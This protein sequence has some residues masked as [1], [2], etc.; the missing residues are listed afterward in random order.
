M[1]N[2][3]PVTNIN[4]MTSSSLAIDTNAEVYPGVKSSRLSPGN[5]SCNLCFREDELIGVQLN[6]RNL[7]EFERMVIASC[8]IKFNKNNI[9]ITSNYSIK[10]EK[11][12]RNEIKQG[13]FAGK[14][15]IF[16]DYCLH[17]DVDEPDTMPMQT[18]SKNFFDHGDAPR[19][20]LKEQLGEVL[21]SLVDKGLLEERFANSIEQFVEHAKKT[22]KKN[23][24]VIAAIKR[25]E[26][27]KLKE[28]LPIDQLNILEL[29]SLYAAIQKYRAVE[30]GV[31]LDSLVYGE[32]TSSIEQNEGNVPL[33]IDSQTAL[34]EEK[35]LDREPSIRQPVATENATSLARANSFST[36]QVYMAPI[37]LPALHQVISSSASANKTN[38]SIHASTS[39][40][41]DKQEL[42]EQNKRILERDMNKAWNETH[43][44]TELHSSKTEQML[45][46]ESQSESLHNTTQIKVNAP[47]P[48]SLGF[49]KERSQ[50][51]RN[52]SIDHDTILSEDKDFDKEDSMLSDLTLEAV[53]SLEESIQPSKF[54][55]DPMERIRNFG[56]FS[57]N[58]RELFAETPIQI[59]NQQGSVKLTLAKSTSP[60]TLS[61]YSKRPAI[62]QKAESKHSERI[63]PTRGIIKATF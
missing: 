39:S 36:A 57:E 7:P 29:D 41:K 38:F 10:Q 25:D 15:S 11:Q 52:N 6:Y 19:K 31:Y 56:I 58:G 30:C 32:M 12:E 33:Q 4:I 45:T 50:K 20:I 1:S 17:P 3:R 37:P 49:L 55:S 51:D 54:T 35:K 28:L 63:L 26:V 5:L 22:A 59:K 18:T 42:G 2:T 9:H 44:P 13:L 47:K 14:R 8:D 21:K 16:R 62:A 40:L 60:A 46:A 53:E 23:Q 43:Q 61:V 24:E 34:F 48:L 27:G